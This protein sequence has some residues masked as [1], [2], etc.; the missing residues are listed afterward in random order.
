MPATVLILNPRSGGGTTG[1]RLDTL[2]ELASQHLGEHEVWL[3]E[4]RGHATEL[5]A[6]ARDQ[7]CARVLSVGGDGTANEVVNGLMAGQGPGEVVFGL[8]PGGTGGDLVRALGIPARAPEAL[9]SLGSQEVRRVDVL[10]VDFLEATA[11]SRRRYCINVTG[12]GLNGEVVKRVN[13]GSKAIG[14]TFSF[15]TATLGG[16][17]AYRTSEVEVRW[18]DGEGREGAWSGRLMAGFLANG[19]YC[20][21]G[22][23]VGRGG[24]LHDGLAD[25]TLV[26]D[27]GPVRTLVSVPR[28]FTGTMERVKGVLRTTVREIEARAFQGSTVRVDVD[29]EQPGILPIRAT[30]LPGVLKVTGIWG[31]SVADL[32]EAP[33][34][35]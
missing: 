4:A 30:L 22:M 31:D 18:V 14:G 21:G 7:G 29:G 19:H 8:V 27:L 28:L 33:T 24:S 16:I 5:A 2:R 6:R 35:H 1:R 13:S 32:G 25:L 3:T 34:G 11:E 23:W 20:G 10:A 26:P 17:A 9:A 15:L 12:F